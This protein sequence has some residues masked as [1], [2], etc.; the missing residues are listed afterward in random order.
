M[1]LNMENT[2]LVIK[3]INETKLPEYMVIDY[4]IKIPDIFVRIL[5]KNFFKQYNF[6]LMY[7]VSCIIN[8]T[9]EFLLIASEYVKLEDFYYICIEENRKSDVLTL[10]ILYKK[11]HVVRYLIDKGFTYTQ[12]H[13]EN[14]TNSD[15]IMIFIDL[16]IIITQKIISLCIKFDNINAIKY[17]FENKMYN[18][19]EHEFDIACI[20]DSIKIIN[21]FIN[22]NIRSSNATFYCIRN[23]NHSLL[24]FLLERGFEANIN[25]LNE[26][27][28]SDDIKS[29]KLILKYKTFKLN[30][31]L[32]LAEDKPEIHKILLSKN[33]SCI[34][35]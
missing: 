35:I 29:V 24:K 14:S 1:Y 18:F 23:K 2:E 5:N 19:S 16:K 31:S 28:I 6:H 25:T 27:I 13:I 15:I 8:K 22:N 7:S 17:V 20:F 12:Y 4:I 9:V 32:K 26:A 33:Y 3:R 30:E 11:Y 21:F 10:F 34:I